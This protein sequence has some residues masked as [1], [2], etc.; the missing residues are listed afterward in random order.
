MAH[1]HPIGHS[2][3]PYDVLIIG[4]GP[5]AL[6]LLLRLLISHPSTLYTDLEQSR[7]LRVK[8]T[9]LSSTDAGAEKQYLVVDESGQWM[10]R[11]KRLFEG[12]GIDWLRSL[13]NVH[14]D[15]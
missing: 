10:G 3:N 2:S 7:L 4:S 11:W 14:P 9:K 12:Y 6:T 8:K 5:H 13:V 1:K 15:A